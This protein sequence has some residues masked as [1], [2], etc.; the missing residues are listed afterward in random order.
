MSSAAT[1]FLHPEYLVESPS[2]TSAAA[3]VEDAQ[4]TESGMSGHGQGQDH[5]VVSV[6]EAVQNVSL[7]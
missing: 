3:A 2:S 4:I 5:A 1:T 6:E 7:H